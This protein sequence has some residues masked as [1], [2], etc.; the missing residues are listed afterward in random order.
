MFE[1]DIDLNEFSDKELVELE[2]EREDRVMELFEEVKEFVTAVQE[3]I[4]IKQE[5]ERRQ[6]NDKPRAKCPH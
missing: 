5:R 6:D 3:L 1:P 4:L 2:V